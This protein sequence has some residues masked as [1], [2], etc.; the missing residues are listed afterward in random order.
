M[1]A[2]VRIFLGDR[3]HET[4]VGF[5]HLLL[6]LTGFPLALLDGLDDAAEVVD[7]NAHL[8]RELRDVVAQRVDLAD[9]RGDELLPLFGQRADLVEPVGLQLVAEVVVE[10]VL[11]ANAMQVRKAH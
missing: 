6:R 9:F 5:H 2:T 7:R 8:L 3:D 1:Q 10:E 4:E 11:P